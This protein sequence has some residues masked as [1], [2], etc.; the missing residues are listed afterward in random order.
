MN[1]DSLNEKRLSNLQN[2]TIDAEYAVDQNHISEILA[3]A[4]CVWENM[5]EKELLCDSEKL[6]GNLNLTNN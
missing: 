2:I 4:E 1:R 3:S 6:A 5:L